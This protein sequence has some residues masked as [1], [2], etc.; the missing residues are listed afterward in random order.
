MVSYGTPAVNGTGIRGL[1]YGEDETGPS[2]SRNQHRRDSSG[3][4]WSYGKWDVVQGNGFDFE[5]DAKVGEP[6]LRLAFLANQM[7]L[8]QQNSLGH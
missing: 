2:G 3:I 6:W 1:Y 5:D 8:R 4:P 7:L